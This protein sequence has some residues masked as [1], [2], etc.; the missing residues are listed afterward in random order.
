MDN[1]LMETTTM[2]NQ[3]AL[4]FVMDVNRFA[5]NCAREDKPSGSWPEWAI[6]MDMELTHISHEL[7][8]AAKA[9]IAYAK[10]CAK[11]ECYCSSLPGSKCDFCTGLR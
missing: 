3:D 7:R 10:N 2:T 8:Q 1:L 6:E 9:D 4:G 5:L 11:R